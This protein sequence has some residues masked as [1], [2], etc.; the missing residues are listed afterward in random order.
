[1]TEPPR[2]PDVKHLQVLWENNEVEKG[3]IRDR[4]YQ[5]GWERQFLRIELSGKASLKRRCL[6]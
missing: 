5:V 1:M 6:S 4:E 3:Q 2:R